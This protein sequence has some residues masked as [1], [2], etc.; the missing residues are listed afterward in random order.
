MLFEI[1]DSFSKFLKNYEKKS[2]GLLSLAV[3]EIID[4]FFIYEYKIFVF[5]VFTL[6]L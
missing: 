3:S 1:F 5:P 2:S 4:P 6:G